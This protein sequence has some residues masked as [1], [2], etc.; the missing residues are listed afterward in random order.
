[1]LW[2]IFLVGKGQIALEKGVVASKA[3]SHLPGGGWSLESAGVRLAGVSTA[4]SN[5]SF[6]YL[7]LQGLQGLN[8]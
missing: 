2:A 6:G 3:A 5:F 1:M 7:G 8:L 4:T